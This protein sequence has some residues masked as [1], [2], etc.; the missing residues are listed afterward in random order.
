M[1]CLHVRWMRA[2]L[3]KIIRYRVTTDN[4]SSKREMNKSCDGFAIIVRSAA[5]SW[6]GINGFGCS[7][8]MWSHPA[9]S[10]WKCTWKGNIYYWTEG[11]SFLSMPLLYF[12]W[13]LST[14]DGQSQHTGTSDQPCGEIYWS[15]LHSHK[16]LSPELWQ[17]KQPAATQPL[18][19]ASFWDSERSQRA[20][21]KN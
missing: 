21:S 10:V 16:V 4:P 8:S 13:V 11:T 9:H 5:L 15:S 3:P 12:F 7:S 1:Q 17:G 20:L 19:S 18:T 2:S 6:N 14:G